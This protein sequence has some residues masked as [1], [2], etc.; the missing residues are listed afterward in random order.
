MT[1]AAVTTTE[2]RVKGARSGLRSVKWRSSS[3]TAA[4]ASSVCN[5][6]QVSYAFPPR[7]LLGRHHCL[8]HRV[9]S[10]LGSRW[11]LAASAKG[12]ETI[13]KALRDAL[14][15]VGGISATNAK[16][17]RK[18]GWSRAARTVCQPIPFSP[19]SHPALTLSRAA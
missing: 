11:A 19:P 8:H 10:A 1:A 9:L 4:L 2:R 5:S 7:A 17:V 12:A 6:T 3:A 18:V 13:E 16:D 14:V 15:A